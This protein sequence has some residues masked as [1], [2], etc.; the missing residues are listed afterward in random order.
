MPGERTV[1]RVF[2]DAD[3]NVN[4][5]TLIDGCLDDKTVSAILGTLFIVQQGISNMFKEDTLPPDECEDIR[6]LLDN[7][8]QGD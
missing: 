3:N 7:S 1:V 4:Y 6:D 2:L 5:D 8:E